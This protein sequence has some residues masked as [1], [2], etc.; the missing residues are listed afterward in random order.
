MDRL[1]TA[2][3]PVTT[4][5]LW[6]GLIARRNVTLFTSQWKAGKTTLITGLLQQFATGGTFLDRP[7]AAA[8]VLL[9][10]EE[11]RSTWADR[12]KRMPLGGHCRLLARPFPRRPTPEQWERL[13]EQAMEL[14]A[15]GELDLLVIDPLARFLPGSTDSDLNALNLLLDPL[16]RLTDGGAG[17]TILHHPRKRRSEEG[18]TARGHGGLL[19]AV[20]VIVELGRYGRCSRRSGGGSCSRCRATRR[21][22]SSSCT[23]GTRP[24]GSSSWATRTWP[25][26][27]RTGRCCGRS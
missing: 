15:A 12:V 10:S 24:G 23:S 20:D 8:K 2:A 19:A 16:Q 1:D 27:R 14:Q 3:A 26:F 22:R 13:V 25:G 21:R 11:P 4:D 6:H 9:V 7:V 18:S 17:V 5:W